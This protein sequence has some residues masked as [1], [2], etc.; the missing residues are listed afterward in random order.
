MGYP[1]TDVHDAS[2]T[3]EGCGRDQVE[4]LSQDIPRR[5]PMPRRDKEK[6]IPETFSSDTKEFIRLLQAHRVKY[7]IV[8]GVAV[9]FH[10]HV[11]FTGDVDFFYADDAPNIDALFDALKSF[12]AGSIP[13]IETS[14]ELAETGVIIQFG[15]PPN[16]IDLMNRIDG[17]GFAHAWDTRIEFGIPDPSGEIVAFM[18][19]R[20]QLIQNKRSTGRPKDQEDLTFLERA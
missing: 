13:G 18:L 17:V 14:E 10:G 3:D 19:S 9:I 15:R 11:R 1:A 7:V 4:D 12:W 5:T 6:I 20:E 8:G 2:R 16:R